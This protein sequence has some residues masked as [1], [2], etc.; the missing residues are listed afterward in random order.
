MTYA[1]LDALSD[2]LATGLTS[3]GRPA[4]VRRRRAVAVTAVPAARR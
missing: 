1:E 3:R 2:R 4:P